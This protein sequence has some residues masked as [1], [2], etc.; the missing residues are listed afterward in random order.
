MFPPPVQE[1]TKKCRIDGR[2]QGGNQEIPILIVGSEKNKV[3]NQLLIVVV[4]VIQRQIKKKKVNKCRRVSDS[5]NTILPL[6]DVDWCA[7]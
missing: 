7:N 1:E 4:M 5:Q 6:F 2:V 3:K